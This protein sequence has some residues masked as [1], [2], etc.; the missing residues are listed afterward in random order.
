MKKLMMDLATKSAIDIAKSGVYRYAD[1][2]YYEILL[3]ANSVDDTPVQEVD[4]ASG[5]KQPK[6]NLL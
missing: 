3:F 6:E 2:P 5:E 1:S 4:L